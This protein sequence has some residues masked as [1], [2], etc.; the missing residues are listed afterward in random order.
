MLWKMFFG[1]GKHGLVQDENRVFARVPIV[2]FRDRDGLCSCDVSYKNYLPL[3][4]TRLIRAY[5]EM[6]PR[7]PVLAVVI[8]RMAKIVGIASTIHGYISSYAW[9]LM[10]I[11]YLQVIHGL[12][13]LH[14]VEL[15]LKGLPEEGLERREFATDFAEGVGLSKVPE[16][17]GPG[18]LLRGFF[19]FY[20]NTFRWTSEVVSVRLGRRTWHSDPELHENLNRELG[21]CI[22]DPIQRSRNLNF[23][24]SADRLQ[25]IREVIEQADKNLASGAGLPEFMLEGVSPELPS[26]WLQDPEEK[27]RGS[28][29]CFLKVPARTLSCECQYCGQVFE[30]RQ[31]LEHEAICKT[32]MP[33]A[34][35]KD[36]PFACAQCNKTFS[37][38]YDLQQHQAATRHAGTVTLRS[39]PLGVPPAGAPSNA[40]RTCSS[41]RRTRAT[42]AVLRPSPPTGPTLVLCA[43]K[44]SRRR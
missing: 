11:Y 39:G 1:C 7:L 25:Q 36:K 24:L 42:Q 35:S 14:E 19:V 12:P 30:H 21:L 4:N 41:T 26:S 38:L 43:A 32:H 15:S 18:A 40:R 31:L 23:A 2:S 13:S 22:E 28:I 10:I 5:S 29:G 27:L 17:L 20:A 6:E 9:T 34:L 16:E 44:P 3:F 33:L 37:Q 8:K